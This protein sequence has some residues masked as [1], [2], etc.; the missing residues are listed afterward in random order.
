MEDQTWDMR[1]SITSYKGQLYLHTGRVLEGVEIQKESY[2]IR[3]MAIPQDLKETAYGAL[4]A[5]NA[6]A[7]TNNFAEAGIWYKR[8][9]DHWLEFDRTHG[10][11]K[12]YP[13]SIK[14]AFATS[15]IW[16]GERRESRELLDHALRQVESS[17][18][19]DWASA[20]LW[21]FALLFFVFFVTRNSVY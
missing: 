6:I 4:N 14:R 12:I 7:S 16:S 10:N 11:T 17:K 1:G 5:A 21:V 3:T 13:S 18:P 20:A 15:L 9:R 19:F 8:A 2:K